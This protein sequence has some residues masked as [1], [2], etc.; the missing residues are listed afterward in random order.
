MIKYV[1]LFN[2]FALHFKCKFSF[3]MY[4]LCLLILKFRHWIFIPKLKVK[5]VNFIYF[6]TDGVL[7]C[8]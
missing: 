7:L 4:V 1:M 6:A 8:D 2:V 5:I 3:F